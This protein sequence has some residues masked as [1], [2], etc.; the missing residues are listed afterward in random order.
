MN[1]QS[2]A[3]KILAKQIEEAAAEVSEELEDQALNA[4]KTGV[5]SDDM[6]AAMSRFLTEVESVGQLPDGIPIAFDLAMRL[7]S[8]SYGGLEDGGCGNGSRPSDPILDKLLSELALQRREV[9]P[10]WNYAKALESLR[11]QNKKLEEYGIDGFC[12]NSIKLMD[13]WE[14]PETAVVDLTV[15]QESNGHPYGNRIEGG[16]SCGTRNL[17]T[18]EAMRQW[19]DS[20]VA[21]SK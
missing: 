18:V 6:S 9:E 19:N 12:E 20:N 7:G 15:N 2:D 3:A 16:S 14:K 10:T 4:R 13:G 21:R 8:Y 17:L 1:Q 11:K 5:T